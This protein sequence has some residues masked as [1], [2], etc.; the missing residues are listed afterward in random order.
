MRRFAKAT[1]WLVLAGFAGAGAA[2]ADP[3]AS[4]RTVPWVDD[5]GVTHFTR[6]A[7]PRVATVEA[8]ARAL[9]PTADRPLSPPPLVRAVDEAPAVRDTD[10][11]R[12]FDAEQNWRI[13]FRGARARIT[14]LERH[15]DM[16][17]DPVLRARLEG[18]LK[19]ALAELGYLDH[20]ART[21]NIPDVW[22][23]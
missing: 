7:P 16:Q 23:Q 15:R 2:S 17:T 22:R 20:S 8:P 11:A 3:P 13:A 9:D 12:Q 10:A 6:Q 14:L 5:H 4:G 19:D 18:E 21:Q 1:R